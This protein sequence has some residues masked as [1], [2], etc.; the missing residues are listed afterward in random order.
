MSRYWEWAI[1]LMMMP[2]GLL[3]LTT[4]F[5]MTTMEGVRI[6]QVAFPLAAIIVGVLAEGELS[7]DVGHCDDEFQIALQALGGEP[8]K[9]IMFIW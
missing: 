7:R 3:L 5:D 2:C 4:V 8:D 6:G 1:A 9:R